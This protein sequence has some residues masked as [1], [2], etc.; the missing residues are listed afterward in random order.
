[1]AESRI[2]NASCRGCHAKFEPLAFGLEKFDGLG[3][4]HEVDEHGNKLREDGEIL[5]PGQ[6]Q[7]VSYQTTAELMGLLAGSERVRKG[8][9]RKVTQFALGR[10]LSE[11]DGPI[12]DQ[13]DEAAQKGGGTY[14]SLI[15]A[16]VLSD[17]VQTT[18]TET[19]VAATADSPEAA[20]APQRVAA[21]LQALYTFQEGGGDVVRDVSMAGEPLSLKL[22]DVQAVRWSD[23]GLTVLAPT[24]IAAERP[25]TKLIEAI[26]KSRAV[27]LEAWITPRDAHQS[28]PARIVSL[29]SGTGARNF[30]L[31]QD[32]DKYDVRFRTTQ[33]DG[34]GLPSLA[35]SSGAVQTRLTHVVY[36]RD[37]A[38]KATLYVNG[39]EQGAREVAG[40]LSNWDANFRLTMA[41]ETTKDRLWQGTLHLIAMYDRALSPAEVQQN[42]AA[43]L[44]TKK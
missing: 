4:Y 34:N 9:A 24:L 23:Q 44:A 27:T 29:S 16:I 26:K 20:K 32:G 6:D 19:A 3:A 11:A 10:P 18:R 36:T 39:K 30:T 21:G 43:G 38:G 15:T 2:A 40:G 1:V 42:H 22:S 5:F 12:V 41:N 7:P 31:G 33:S 8:I 28:G 37:K 17:L 35:T 13:I 14:A 25:P